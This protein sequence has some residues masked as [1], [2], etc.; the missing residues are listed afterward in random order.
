MATLHRDLS[1]RVSIEVRAELERVAL[2]L[3]PAVQAMRDLD[4]LTTTVELALA[5]PA[6][7]DPAEL[8]PVT[9][10]EFQHATRVAGLDRCME[11]LG[12][13]ERAIPGPSLCLDE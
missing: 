7:L 10:D 9:E 5:V 8:A 2:V 1:T 12:A 4:Q 13:I 11:L 3:E 6:S